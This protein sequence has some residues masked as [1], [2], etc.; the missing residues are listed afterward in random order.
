MNWNFKDKPNEPGCYAIIYC[1]EPEEGLFTGSSF[2]DGVMWKNGLP[3]T[4][5]AGPFED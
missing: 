1:W 3:V 5:W 2:W 4:S